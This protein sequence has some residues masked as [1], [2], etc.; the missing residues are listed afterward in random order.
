MENK[1]IVKSVELENGYSQIFFEDGTFVIIKYVASS[2]ALGIVPGVSEEEAPEE[3]APEEEAPEEEAPEEEEN[4]D[5]DPWVEEDFEDM[6]REELIETIEDEEIE[7]DVD[8]DDYE[9]SKK[10]LRKLRKAVIA[11]LVED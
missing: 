5:D 2:Q 8:V 3:E 10:G 6:D 11:I 4:L 9:D 1:V 7:D